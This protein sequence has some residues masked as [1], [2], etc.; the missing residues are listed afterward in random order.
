MDESTEIETISVDSFTKLTD[1]CL[2]EFPK[3]LPESQRDNY[4][5][6]QTIFKRDSEKFIT[7]LK[8]S[9]FFDQ[10]NWSKNMKN[11]FY[12]FLNDGSNEHNYLWNLIKNTAKSGK[13]YLDIFDFS[14]R[15]LPPI[16]G[17]LNLSTLTVSDVDLKSLP[18]ELFEIKSLRKLEIRKAPIYEIPQEISNLVNLTVLQL[19]RIRNIKIPDSITQLR[20]L[21]ELDVSYVYLDNLSSD[22]CKFVFSQLEKFDCQANY[23]DFNALIKSCTGES[24]LKWLNL[25]ETNCNVP[26]ELAKFPKLKSLLMSYIPQQLYFNFENTTCGLLEY[27]QLNKSKLLQENFNQFFTV[28]AF[29][30][31]VEAMG[32]TN[33]MGHSV[34]D[35]IFHNVSKFWSKK[36]AERIVRMK[37]QSAV[38]K[39]KKQFLE[40]CQVPQT[41]LFIF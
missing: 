17:N 9:G 12:R 24:S 36:H 39:L 38:R 2:V 20:R 15:R 29:L 33:Q 26:I 25:N 11:I 14:I 41:Q 35:G 16:I 10:N 32:A 4:C 13:N 40:S 3:D 7:M 22:I 31:D 6:F 23:F 28:F 30:N 8:D 27:L 21:K 19:A 34:V 37:N 5:R 18:L 1:Q